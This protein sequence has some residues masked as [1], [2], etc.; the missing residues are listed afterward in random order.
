MPVWFLSIIAFVQSAI[1]PPLL[2]WKPSKVRKSKFEHSL[3]HF[4]YYT[5]YWSHALFILTKN[6]II[7]RRVCY[8]WYSV[9][10]RSSWKYCCV[11]GYI[12]CSFRCTHTLKSN[13]KVSHSA[14]CWQGAPVQNI[15]FLVQPNINRNLIWTSG[16]LSWL[17]WMHMMTIITGIIVSCGFMLTDR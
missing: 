2:S 12:I 3:K 14:V 11:V 6:I 7:I 10:C 9:L 17:V 1:W 5:A 16:C 15:C 8:T 4:N 13:D